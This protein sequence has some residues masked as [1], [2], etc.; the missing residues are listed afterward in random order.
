M[1]KRRG[2]I[3]FYKS[4]NP[5]SGHVQGGNRPVIIVSNDKANKYSPVLLAVPCTKQKKKLIPTHV[6]FQI[7]DVDNTALVE[8][9]GPVDVGDLV[10]F[11]G[12]VDDKTLRQIDNA[13]KIALGLDNRFNNAFKNSQ[14]DVNI[15]IDS[16]QSAID[17]FYKRYPH[18]KPAEDENVVSQS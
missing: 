14:V 8:Q 18:L 11:G 17:K 5:P 12:T 9:V 6:K 16:D 3:W 4:P 13:L 15:T 10:F 7:K 2:D 1:E